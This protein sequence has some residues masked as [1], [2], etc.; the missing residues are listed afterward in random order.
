MQI[1]NELNS[2]IIDFSGL[3]DPIGTKDFEKNHWESQVLHIQRGNPE[4]FSS[5]FS[6]KDLD[7][8]LEYTRPR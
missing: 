3:I 7:Y 5:L 4:F 6:I 8:L 1:L 2:K